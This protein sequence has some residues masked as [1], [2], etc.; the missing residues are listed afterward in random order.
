MRLPRPRRRATHPLGG[1][2]AVPDEEQCAYFPGLVVH[3]DV[4]A[5]IRD[6][7]PEADPIGVEP[8]GSTA[9]ARR[10]RRG[11]SA[12]EVAR[13]LDRA[14]RRVRRE[15]AN[16]WRVPAGGAREP[17]TALGAAFLR[18]RAGSWRPMRG[19]VA[20]GEAE[21]GP[22]RGRPQIVPAHRRRRRVR[23]A[24]VARGGGGETRVGTSR[25][26]T[27]PRRKSTARRLVNR[28]TARAFAAGKFDDGERRRARRRVRASTTGHAW[29]LGSR[30]RSARG[31]RAG[32]LRRLAS[33][34]PV[35]HR[36]GHRG[37]G[38]DRE[39]ATVRVPPGPNATIAA[40][41][42]DPPVRGH[43][44]HEPSWTSTGRTGA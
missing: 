30:R 9:N 39:D 23:V 10:R 5:P 37:D 1:L 38:N 31:G 15:A 21:R 24:G 26:S 36:R 2:V 14:A 33:H 29:G 28:G 42:A 4:R 35:S 8:T 32:G 19:G 11:G 16:A 27:A 7:G 40:A 41:A 17:A 43:H 13:G 3:V 34:R 20:G 44:R 22:V 6:G 25:C 12:G 18:T